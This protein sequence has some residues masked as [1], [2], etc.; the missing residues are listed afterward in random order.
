MPQHMMKSPDP[1][2]F[3]RTFSTDAQLRAIGASA[4]IT[5][6]M[7]TSPS[8]GPAISRNCLCNFVLLDYPVAAGATAGKTSADSTLFR[9]ARR[10]PFIDT[11]CDVCSIQ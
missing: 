9:C 2:A 10:R 4:K 7:R 1:V 8:S 5:I 6:Q 3:S 11:N